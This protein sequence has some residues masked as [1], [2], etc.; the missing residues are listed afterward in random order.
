MRIFVLPA[1]FSVL[2]IWQCGYHLIFWL[3]LFIALVQVIA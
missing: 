1:Q 2:D 3:Q